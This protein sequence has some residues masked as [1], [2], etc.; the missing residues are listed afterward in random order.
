MTT[1]KTPDGQTL[2]EYTKFPRQPTPCGVVWVSLLVDGNRVR[3]YD[4]SQLVEVK[5]PFDSGMLYCYPEEAPNFDSGLNYCYP[6]PLLTVVLY[7]WQAESVNVKKSLN[8][9]IKVRQVSL[10]SEGL[11]VA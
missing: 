2:E 4:L 9:R 11:R 7:P 6:M 5:S 3:K 10:W 1:F 8:S